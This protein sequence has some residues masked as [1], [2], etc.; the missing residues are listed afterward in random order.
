MGVAPIYAAHYIKIRPWVAEFLDGLLDRF[1]ISIYTAATGVYA[2]K[3]ADMLGRHVMD[4]R[5]RKRGL[6]EEDGFCLNEVE[7]LALR[8]EVFV[9][10]QNVES[11]KGYISRLNDTLKEG[12][13]NEEEGGEDVNVGKDDAK[14][15]EEANKEDRTDS[16]NDPET[17]LQKEENQDDCTDKSPKTPTPTPITTTTDNTTPPTTNPNPK[18]RRVKFSYVSDSL[19]VNLARL[20][21][22]LKQA[23]AR[24]TEALNLRK[25][26]F[27][28][29]VVSRTDVTDL[30]SDVKS[31]KRVFPCGGMLAAIVDD[32]EDVWANAKNNVTGRRGEPPDNL[33]LVRPYRWKPFIHYAEVNNSAGEDISK[34]SKGAEVQ[35]GYDPTIE[36]EEMQLLWTNDIL[37]RVHDRYY[38]DTISESERIKMTVPS[39]LKQMRNDVLGASARKTKIIFSGL[40][41]L[42]VQHTRMGNDNYPRPPVVRYAEELGAKVMA[43]VSSDVTHIVAARDG[44][45]KI[46]RARHIPGCAIV[47]A[48]W[49]MECYW[50]IA[51]KDIRNH[52]IGPPPRDAPQRLLLVG[53]DSEDEDDDEDD[54]DFADFEQEEES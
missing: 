10:E 38:S 49:L 1:E 24:E 18:K 22:K 51:L 23:E 43:D 16:T 29:R 20:K 2:H 35:D 44:T 13:K 11:R 7:L 28:N 34:E 36:K 27:G 41:P 17:S 15:Q 52:L 42:H 30:G 4:Y 46:K 39:I 12:N 26:I 50:S 14:K 25:K 9:A 54:D 33:L 21:Q 45:E 5:R 19:S 3:V 6:V 47:T 31:L 8:R 32:R 48:K 37:T 40:V 53:S